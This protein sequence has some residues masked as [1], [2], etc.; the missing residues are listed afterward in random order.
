[1]Q[2]DRQQVRC[3]LDAL[4]RVRFPGSD[5]EHLPRRQ[6]VGLAESGEAEFAFQV[7]D[8]DLAGALC[9]AISL[10]AAITRRTTSNWLLQRIQISNWLNSNC[11]EQIV[12]GWQDRDALP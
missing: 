9:S 3:V 7:L 12:V 10:P 4:D 5:V 11:H 8:R 6:F 2:Q 1:L